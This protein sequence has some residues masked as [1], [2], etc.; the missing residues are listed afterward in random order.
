MP[1][2]APRTAQ[3]GDGAFGA[4]WRA[5]ARELAAVSDSPSLDAQLLLAAA[6][7]CSRSA[8]LAYPERVLDLEGVAR[9]RVLTAR[10]G[11]GEPLA[12]LTGA[13]EFFGLGLEVGPDV[14]V[15]RPETELMVEEVLA[16]RGPVR[17]VL[18]LATGS[19]AVA[20]ALK[21][22]V[23]ALEVTGADVSGA[24]LHVARA[25][26]ERLGLEIEWVESDWFGALAGR[27]FD[28][29]VCNPPYLASADPHFE[30]PLAFEPRLALDGG[31]DGLDAVRAVLDAAPA[32]LTPGGRLLVEHG[33]EQQAAVARL[34]AAAGLAL[35]AARSDL[36]GKDR[37][38]VLALP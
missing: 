14:L 37:Y 1:A 27:R 29:V 17:R 26:A 7:G 38:V 30:G 36:A 9:F 5:A 35:V 24:A 12:Y 3:G 21:R 32:H 28:V 11:R 8:V 25:N 19:G 2:C 33:F 22:A 13:R 31:P 4:L 18:D 23:P 16:D 10:R 15:P 34:A 6:A 20:L